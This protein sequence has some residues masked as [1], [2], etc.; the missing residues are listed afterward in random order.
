MLSFKTRSY[1]EGIWNAIR[2]VEWKP[3]AWDLYNADL[4]LILLV[5]EAVPLSLEGI[6][7]ENSWYKEV[8]EMGKLAD[9]LHS[10]YYDFN[11]KEEDEDRERFWEL[12]G[13]NYG[14]LWF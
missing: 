12:L 10:H 9:K 2:S 4:T 14:H 6:S 7:E 11:I 5:K 3:R 13:R 1:I 8:E